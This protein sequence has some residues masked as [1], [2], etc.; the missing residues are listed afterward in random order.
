MTKEEADE[1]FVEKEIISKAKDPDTGRVPH[2]IN[3]LADFPMIGRFEF[4]AKFSDL[5]N[6]TYP[7]DPEA[8]SKIV[9]SSTIKLGTT[10]ENGYSFTVQD[11]TSG[12]TVVNGR[13]SLRTKFKRTADIN[14]VIDPSTTNIIDTYVLLESYDDAYRT[15][16]LYDG[17]IQTVPNPPTVGELNKLFESLVSKKSISDQ[18][19]YR[20]VKYK[21]LFGDLASSEVQARFLV[22]KTANSTMSD[23]EI[24]ARVINL[25][26]QYFNIDNWDFGE[27][28]Y[29][30]EMA[31]FIHNNMIGQI[32]QV[33]I[34]PVSSNIQNTD[35]FEI[36]SDSDELFLPVVQSSNVVISNTSKPR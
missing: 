5:D 25:I 26:S 12:T 2:R 16:A 18:V 8:F 19:I 22:T 20:P 21:I 31:A 28:F 34:Q 17:R 6:D 24:Q 32:S 36:T 7:D 27:D 29:F 9:G 33:S 15:W 23:T 1:Y 11:N 30:T 14:Q 13:G 3:H 35:L 4:G 10:T